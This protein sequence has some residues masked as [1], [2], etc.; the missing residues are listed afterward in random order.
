M[1]IFIQKNAEELDGSDFNV[2]FNINDRVYLGLT[3]GAY[4]VDYNKYTGYDEDYRNDEKY[5][6]QSWNRY[7]RGLALM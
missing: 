5:N 6:L 4:D 2:S 7:I 1:Q 3:I